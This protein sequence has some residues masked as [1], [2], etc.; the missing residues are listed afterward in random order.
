MTLNLRVPQEQ[1]LPGLMA[2][3]APRV[4]FAEP[5]V[6]TPLY[7]R[8]WFNDSGR[9]ISIAVLEGWRPVQD[10]EGRTIARLAHCQD[11]TVLSVLMER[12]E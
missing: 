3:P 2:T 11:Q 12:K 7:K 5:P 4:S 9:R 10:A 6:Q 8:H 1:G